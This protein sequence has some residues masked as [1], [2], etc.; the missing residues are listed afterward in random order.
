[1]ASTTHGEPRRRRYLG[2]A[3]TTDDKF[4]INIEGPNGTVYRQD[5]FLPNGRERVPAVLHAA[6]VFIRCA[7]NE[8]LEM[9]SV[10][11]YEPDS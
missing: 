10:K 11:G 4:T 7:L 9:G 3:H 6:T 2:F 5:F 1:M 8:H